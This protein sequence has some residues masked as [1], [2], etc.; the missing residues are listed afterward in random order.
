MTDSSDQP[1]WRPVMAAL[2]NPHC[3]RMYAQ[4]ELGQDA[5]TIGQELSAS[6]RNNAWRILLRSGL[7]REVDAGLVADAEIFAHVL[8]AAPSSRQAR[9]VERYLTGQGTIDRY[10]SDPLEMRELLDFVA[11]R[12]VA[13]DEVV[14]EKILNERLSVFSD[15]VALLRRNLVDHEVLERTRSGSEYAR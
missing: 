8:A 3:R 15:D 13:D 6:K 9:G 10:P 7:V 4:V 1:D 14:S 11:R 5:A 12:T 2:A